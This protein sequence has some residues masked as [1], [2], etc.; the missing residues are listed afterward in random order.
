MKFASWGSF[1]NSENMKMVREHRNGVEDEVVLSLD[2]AQDAE[3]EEV[4]VGSG[5][6]QESSLDSPAGDGD[7]GVGFGYAAKFSSHTR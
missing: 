3:E 5:L 7:E 2:S 1:R 4:E 6:E